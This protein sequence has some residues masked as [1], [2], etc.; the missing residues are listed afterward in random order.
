LQELKSSEKFALSDIGRPTRVLIAD[1]SKLLQ[2]LL[3]LILSAHADIEVVGV[4]NDGQEC[5]DLAEVVKPDLI[6]LDIDMPV[7]DGI[8]TLKELRK[9][10][11][12]PVIIVSALPVDDDSMLIQLREL[13]ATATVA[14]NFSN[15]PIGL[16]AFDSE[17][18]KTIRATIKSK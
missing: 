2:K 14:K 4:A 7:K 15:G 18:M 17:L 6:T 5:L 3:M 16:A 13:G 9:S 12:I 8:E 11:D 1:D 10:S